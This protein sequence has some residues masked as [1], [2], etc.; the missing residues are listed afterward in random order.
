M[1]KLRSQTDLLTVGRGTIITSTTAPSESLGTKWFNPTT[2]VT[3]QRTANADGT[4][5]WLDVSSGGIGTSA[6]R[7]VDFVGDIDP[8]KTTNLGAVG[9]VYYNREKNRHFTCTTATNNA[10]VWSGRYAGSG[11]TVTEYIA[12]STTYRVHSFLNSGTFSVEDALSVDILLV[13]GGGGAGHNYAGG[14][15]AGQVIWG[16]G[17][18]INAGTQT[19]VVGSGGGPGNGLAGQASTPENM[20]KN[21]G[22]SSFAMTTG[23]A[24]TYT[25]GGGGGSGSYEHGD[26]PMHPPACVGSSGGTGI[27]GSDSHATV[28]TPSGVAP[29][30][31]NST[32]T[33]TSYTNVG[34]DGSYNSSHT[35]GGSRGGGP[36]GGSGAAGVL[37]VT[38][39]SVAQ[40]SGGVGRSTLG[41][42]NATDTTAFLMAAVAGTDSSNAATTGSSSGTIY[43]AA[44][45]GAS[46]EGSVFGIGGDGGGGNGGNAAS[47]TNGRTNT[48]SGG[49]GHTGYDKTGSSGGSGIVIVRYALS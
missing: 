13:G 41:S 26:T 36:G 1:S 9:S 32:G 3:Y 42:L 19:V 29:T 33:W 45:G 49:G 17:V 30:G 20:G 10:Q 5:F 24:F 27:A 22:I 31:G 44:G 43:I 2:A 28:Q 11:G 15:G 7:G 39:P 8:S 12:G 35:S 4:L 46:H 34:G 47:G 21:G 14:G 23:S 6:G 37:V 16:T 48:G 40:M 25:A 38:S 18:T